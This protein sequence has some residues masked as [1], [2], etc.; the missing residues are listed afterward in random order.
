MNE[1]YCKG[2]WGIP[3]KVLYCQISNINRISYMYS[4]YPYVCLNK[5]LQLMCAIC[6]SRISVCTFVFINKLDKQRYQNRSSPLLRRWGSNVTFLR[7]FLLN[8][9]SK[10]DFSHS[11]DV[12]R[13]KNKHADWIKMPNIVICVSLKCNRFPK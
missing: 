6:S 1:C 13:S 3:N 10:T 7:I 4:C 12:I 11:M 8:I 5:S 2:N 9:I